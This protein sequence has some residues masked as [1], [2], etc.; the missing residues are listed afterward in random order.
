MITGKTASGFEYAVNEKALGDWRF[1]KAMADLDS[2]DESK[3]LRAMPVVVSLVL[4]KD[5]DKFMEHI[6]DEDGYQ[7]TEA[8]FAELKDIFDA[9]KESKAKNS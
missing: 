3:L 7:P 8:I 4:G 1:L 2:G 5:E 9:V 6:T